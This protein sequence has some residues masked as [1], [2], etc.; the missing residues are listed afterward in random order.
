MPSRAVQGTVTISVKGQ[1]ETRKKS[2]KRLGV[3]SENS[4]RGSP[5]CEGVRTG[6]INPRK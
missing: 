6:V 3:F 1:E 5:P 2:R 4:R